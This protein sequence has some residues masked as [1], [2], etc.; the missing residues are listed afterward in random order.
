M[1]SPIEWSDDFEA[2]APLFVFGIEPAWKSALP[3]CFIDISVPFQTFRNRSYET[4]NAGLFRLREDVGR[5][6]S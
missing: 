5:S 3:F 4:S 1:A 2:S 6:N